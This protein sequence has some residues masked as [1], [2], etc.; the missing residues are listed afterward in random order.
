MRC[1][2]KM[3]LPNTEE[4]NFPVEIF[5]GGRKSGKTNL[6]RSLLPVWMLDVTIELEVQLQLLALSFPEDAQNLVYKTL[7]Q[8][9]SLFKTKLEAA[10]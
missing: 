8:Q 2:V 6:K 5:V 10:R 1:K 9:V 3:G 7:K 4:F